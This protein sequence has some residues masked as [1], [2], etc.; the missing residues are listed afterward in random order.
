[1]SRRPHRLATALPRISP[2]LYLLLALASVAGLRSAERPAPPAGTSNGLVWL[3]TEFFEDLGGW[4]R[5]WQFVDQMGSPYLMAIGYGTPVADARTTARSV[6]PGQYRLWVRSKDWMP[7]HHPGRFELSLAG[8]RISRAFGASGR[9]GWIWEDG[10]LHTLGGD[11]TLSLHDLAGYYARCDV[12]VLSPDPAWTP[13]VGKDEIRTLRIAHGAL[14]PT[15]EDMGT[16]DVVVAGGGIAGTFAAISAARLGA[17]TILIQNRSLLGGNASTENLVPPVGAMQNRLTKEEI[18]LDPRETGLIEEINLYGKQR[19]FE[20]GKYWPSR[21]R[22]LAE[23]EPNLRILFNTEATGVAMRSPTEIGTVLC[24]NIDTGRRGAV[25]GTLFI[26]CTGSGTIGLKAGAR[27]MIGKE[28][29]DLYGETK[30]PATASSETLGSSLKYWYTKQDK[31]SSFTTPAWAHHFRQC[32]DFGEIR[33]RHPSATGIDNQWVIE[34]GGVT[35]TYD[36]AEEVRD[37]LLRLIYGLWDHIKNHCTDPV[38]KDAPQMSLAWVGHVVG[39]REN[40]RLRGDYVMSE[41]DV[42]Q[43]KLLPDRIAYGGW[44]LDDHPS[45]GFFDKS[46]LKNH[47]HGGLLFSVPYRSLYS[48]NIGNLMMA[49]RNISVSHVALTATRVMLTTGTIG[50]AAGTAAG[51]AI[52]RK[53]NP[54]GIYTNHLA[55]LQQRLL[56]DGSYLIEV[57]NEDPRDLARQAR[58]TASSEGT[59]AVDAINGFSRARLPTTY[60]RAEPRRNAW[61]PAPGAEGEQWLQLAWEQPQA[62]NVVHV[63]FQ[64]RGRLAHRNFTLERHDGSG[65]KKIAD[66]ENPQAHRRLVLPVGPINAQAL[67]VVFRENVHYHGGLCE[68]RVYQED[69]PTVEMIRRINRTVN[70]P[71]ENVLLPWER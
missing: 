34:L 41:T 8:Q 19:Y 60:A 54:R 37:D 63:V 69:E 1:M 9:E 52:R 12:V 2:I 59:P 58:A 46:R 44:G 3:E 65:W 10:G 68:L 70:T 67:R 35:H 29:K 5:D 55:E 64:N 31:V 50:Q 14:S 71:V 11:V 45:L 39:M 62:F 32:S 40:Y 23:A 30:A 7:Q 56:K 26:D 27:Y 16:Y 48:E 38:N 66:V 17:K 18:E 57:P 4:T 13:P 61:T 20:V 42:T 25:R 6:K 53:T 51:L 15:V 21:L 47:T 43:Q 49:G 22:L 24:T 28:P 36:Q 33:D